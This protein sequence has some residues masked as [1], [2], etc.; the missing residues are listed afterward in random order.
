MLKLHVRHRTE[1]RYAGDAHDS[2]NEVR[3][4]PPSNGRQV[5]ERAGIFVKPYVDVHRHTDAFGNE[6]AWFQVEDPHDR[7][8]V[9]AE[10][11]VTVTPHAPHPESVPWS[12]L[13]DPKLRCNLQEF[14]SGSR[15]VHWAETVESFAAELGLDT[16]DDVP[17]WLRATERAVCDNI[18]Y[19]PG[20]TNVDT[21][22]RHVLEVRSG[23]CQ[24]MAHL[25]L[26]LCRRRG[27]P[28]RY[29]SG[30]L[31]E[32]GRDKPA[33]SHAWCDAYV[34]GAGWVE[35]DPTH[36]EPDLNHYIRIGVGRDYMDVPPI[37]GSYLGA[38]TERMIVTVEVDEVPQLAA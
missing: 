16:I 37:R 1:M 4:S 23:V 25:F 34:P 17:V 29:V 18:R 20:S 7:L 28:A 11:V 33:E 6:V 30:W 8:L 26:A 19:L 27:V 3:L 35:F 13:D 2:I 12:A 22:V 38:A 32:P 36:P 24:D 15:L 14:L 9:E 21:T 10:A 31:F 5:V